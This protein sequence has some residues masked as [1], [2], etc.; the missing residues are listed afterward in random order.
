[1]EQP[2]ESG[3]WTVRRMLGPLLLP[4]FTRTHCHNVTKI[5]IG[6]DIVLFRVNRSISQT[7]SCARWM[8]FVVIT[9]GA[10]KIIRPSAP[11]STYTRILTRIFQATHNLR[12]GCQIFLLIRTKLTL[13][14]RT[15]I[16]RLAVLNINLWYAIRGEEIGVGK[17]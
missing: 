5:A 11:G 17:E 4:S 3:D 14:S 6:S 13:Y 1:M 7:N 16:R 12:F 9:S 2:L 15:M 8:A 10:S